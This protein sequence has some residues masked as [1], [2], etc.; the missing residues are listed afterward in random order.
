MDRNLI[1]GIQFPCPLQF[2]ILHKMKNVDVGYYARIVVWITFF[3][4]WHVVDTW[5]LV[6]T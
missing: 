3:C 6:V 4:V 1:P 5:Y 2:S